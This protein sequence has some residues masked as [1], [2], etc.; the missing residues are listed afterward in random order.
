MKICAGCGSEND[1]AATACRECD[2]EKFID[3]NAPISIPSSP[4]EIEVEWVTIRRC[5]SVPDAD[6]VAMELRAA[7]IPV[8]LPHEF[9]NQSL[10]LL[11]IV[12]VR[13]P[14]DQLESAKEI[15]DAPDSPPLPPNSNTL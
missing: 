12:E 14:V 5:R 11:P 8:F 10:Q 2:H 15:L 7:Q 9:A 13:V 3:P 6:A 4:P 1:D